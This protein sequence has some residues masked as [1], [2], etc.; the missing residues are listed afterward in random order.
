[1]NSSFSRFLIRW[2]VGSLGIWISANIFT[3]SITYDDRLRVIIIAGLL[4]AIINSIIKPIVVVL[5]L[6]AIFIQSWAVYD[7][8]K[9][10]YVGAC[11]LALSKSWRSQ[12][13]LLQC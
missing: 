8:N 3:Q 2:F 9:W 11:C 10:L 5:S 13:S 6:P 1:M 12:V 7:S 4:L